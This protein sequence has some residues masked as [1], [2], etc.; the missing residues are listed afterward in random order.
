MRSGR[1][2]GAALPRYVLV[3][4]LLAA[5]HGV[6]RMGSRFTML[7]AG[8]WVERDVRGDL[9][10]HLLSHAPG[11]L[12]P[13]PRSA[14]SCLARRTTSR[15]SGRLAGFGT[16]MLA[17]TS[18]TFVG[19][20]ERHVADRPVAHAL[21]HGAVSLPRPDRQALQPRRRGALDRGAG[22]ARRA[23]RQDPGEPR[24]DG[25]GARLHDGGARDRRLRAAQRRV[26]RQERAP[27]AGAGGV[28]AAH[29]ARLRHRRA[30]R[31][32]AGRQGGGGPAHHAR[33]L[34]G[35]QRL[36]RAPGVADHRARLDAGQREA[37]PR[38]DAARRRDPRRAGARRRASE[39][40]PRRRSP[41]RRRRSS[42]AT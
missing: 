18:L 40:R 33:R 19:T 5:G 39:R 35:L 29:G 27:R 37:R 30:H 10:A 9:Y 4:L 24:G 12:P 25:G 23:V 26:P 22:A 31:P 20:V 2:G 11:L 15:R 13:A 14:T 8:Q 38:R 1:E 36:S 21:R 3:I 42:S 28:V 32:L 16:V 6:A 34:R 41:A 17:G 7:G